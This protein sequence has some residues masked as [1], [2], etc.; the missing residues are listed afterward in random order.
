L[1][2]EVQDTMVQKN[3]AISGNGIIPIMEDAIVNYV[4]SGQLH[5]LKKIPELTEEIWFVSGRRNIDNPIA[6]QVMS[7]FEF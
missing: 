4:K 2:G 5:I 1:V 7:N 3:M 6:N